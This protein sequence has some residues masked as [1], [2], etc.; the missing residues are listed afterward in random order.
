MATTTCSACSKTG[1]S[2]FRVLRGDANGVEAPLVV[3]CSLTCLL[4]WAYT[5]AAMQ[6][7][8]LAYGA[9]STWQKLVEGLKGAR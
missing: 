2:Y 4:K 8:R 5:Y 7:M 3:V 6:G 9:K 1:G